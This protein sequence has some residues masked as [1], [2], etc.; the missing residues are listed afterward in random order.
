MIDDLRQVVPNLYRG[1]RPVCL[2][3]VQALR[4][5][6]AIGAILN[7]QSD[8]LEAP[9]VRE[10]AAWATAVGISFQHQPW[11]WLMP[12]DAAAIANAL[13]LLVAAAAGSAPPLYIHCHDGVDRTGVCCLAFRCAAGWTFGRAAGEMLDAGFHLTRYCWWL[14]EVRAAIGN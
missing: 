10:E 1:P 4:A 3:D 8:V 6:F 9:Q 5:R 7:L 13:P 11:S 12:P 2:A 14:P